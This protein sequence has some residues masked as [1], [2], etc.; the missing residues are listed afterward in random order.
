[1]LERGAKRPV[2]AKRVSI[3]V[4]WGGVWRSLGLGGLKGAAGSTQADDAS[5]ATNAVS[6]EHSEAPESSQRG[7]SAPK[8]L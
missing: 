7:L 3:A 6:E 2:R 4:G 1:M 8:L 5:T